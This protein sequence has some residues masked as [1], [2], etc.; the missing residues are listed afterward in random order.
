MEQG[1]TTAKIKVQLN[2]HTVITIHN[3]STFKM[4]KEKYPDATVIS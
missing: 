3:L 1:K 2:A 4:W